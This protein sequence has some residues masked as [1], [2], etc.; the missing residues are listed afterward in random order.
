MVFEMLQVFKN[1]PL[2]LTRWV[3]ALNPSLRIFPLQVLPF[4]MIHHL[5]RTAK[6]AYPVLVAL[7]FVS[8]TE[9]TLS[10]A[11]NEGE[12]R[13]KGSDLRGVF[14]EN[15][16]WRD[17]NVKSVLWGH[18]KTATESLHKIGCLNLVTNSILQGDIH[19]TITDDSN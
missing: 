6:R 17:G 5:G 18:L 8:N 11:T 3:T 1:K 7:R 14:L 9:Q 13:S 16:W 12:N 4:N 2:R 10:L 19:N 15:S